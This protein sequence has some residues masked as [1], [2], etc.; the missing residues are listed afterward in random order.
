M[1]QVFVLLDGFTP[2]SWKV[3]LKKL[4]RRHVERPLGMRLWI[5]DQP[6]TFSFTA[7]EPAVFRIPR[8]CNLK[9]ILHARLE[10]IPPD[11][12]Y[13]PRF[14][15]TCVDVENGLV[16][17]WWCDAKSL[18]RREYEDRADLYSR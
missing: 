15:I 1:Y 18:L 17:G 2:R 6:F 11:V 3:R 8:P 10:L 4:F 13:L 7:K 14:A 12:D 5:G 16:V 9:E